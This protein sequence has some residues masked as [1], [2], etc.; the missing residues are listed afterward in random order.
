MEGV[1]TKLG[2]KKFQSPTRPQL[3]DFQSPRMLRQIV[4]EAKT[5]LGVVSV[6]MVGSLDDTCQRVLFLPGAPGGRSQITQLMDVKP[7]LLICG[8][9]AEWETSE[10]VRDARAAGVKRSL[11]VMGHAPSEEPGLAWLVEFL[12]QRAPQIKATHIPSQSPF[13]FV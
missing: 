13:T 8:E 6:R 9:V 5:S 7:D 1:V 11:I 2:W 4:M 12:K 10:Y 3:F